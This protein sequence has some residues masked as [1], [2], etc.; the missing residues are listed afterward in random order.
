MLRNFLKIALRNLLRHKAFSVINIAGLA[1]GIS[2]C[3]LIF[4]VVKY[5]LSYEKFQPNYDRIF[6]VVSR[7]SFSDGVTYNP[8]VP[9]PA[10]EAMRL[11][12]PKITTGS[13]LASY[14]S[15]VTVLGANASNLSNDKKF[16]EETG[17]FFCDPQFFKV[18]HYDWLLGSPEVLSEPNNTVLTQ[19]TAKRYFGDWKNAIGQFLKFDNNITV[20]VAGILK[21]PPANT[22]FPIA[23]VTSFETVKQNG[24][25]YSY[26]TQWGSTT[27]NFQVFMLLP[28][29]FSMQNVNSQFANFN[30][31][32]NTNRNPGNTRSNFLQPLS[33]V[34]FDQRFENFG[35]HRASKP[36][37]WTL[38]LIGLFIIVMACINFINLSTAQA[39]GRSKEIGIR[40]V[41]GS[42]RWQLFGQ[43]IGE[44]AF[45]V[46]AALLLAVAISVLCLPSIK[47]IALIKEPIS[48]FS[49]QTFYFIIVLFAA[50]IVLAGL[51][52]ALALSGFSPALALKN[53]IT[54]ASVGGI[55]IRRSLVVTQFAISQI[56]IIGTIV[57]ITQMSFVRNADLGF[58]QDA[59]F[60]INSNAD[61][62]MHA[63]QESFKQQLLQIAGVQKVS[64]SNDVPSSSNGWYSN[65]AFDH[66]PGEKFQVSLKFADEDYFK[67]FGLQFLAGGAFG[68][69]DTV[70]DVVINETMV[71]KLG[72]KNPEEAI[73][74]EIQIGRNKWNRISGVLRD[75]KTS[76]LRE[77]IKPTLIGSDKNFYSVTA[78]KLH[79][80][81]IT[82]TK[83]NIERVWN[84]S[85]PEYAFTSSYLDE[86]IASFYEQDYQFALLYKI[87]AGIAIFISCL[88][89]YGLVSFMA[90]QKTK[91]IGIRKVLGASV[92]NIIYLFSKEFTLLIFIGSIIAIPIAYF[93]M[94][95]W[96]QNFV[97]RIKMNAGIFIIAIVLSL[98]IAWIAVGYKSIKAALVNPVKS[99]KSE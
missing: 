64:F 31:K 21:D 61:S 89:L 79:S 28:P 94:N 36:T 70:K 67:T 52:P 7:D 86:N 59:V 22:D 53:K 10:L 84:K 66:R 92:K 98:F 93:M 50:V 24:G 96:L 12:F 2:A 35:D 60:L 38:S 40:K 90:V 83:A 95:N 97:F 47:L 32:N 69:S 3:L 65:F 74:K 33:E 81:N 57:A 78:I 62:T 51:Y 11:D 75:F 80:S 16:I 73:G 44:T 26:N 99:L 18:F 56:L 41:L 17:F 34:H 8:G 85:F 72:L 5:E 58:N 68:K 49:W 39:V 19:K 46:L 48:L 25:I 20:K 71:K 76:S 55:S 30:S 87:F 4:T 42:Y 6:H 77:D 54:S 1:I 63:R 9:F 45:I 13:L 23:I 82:G 88:G 37:L 91:E 27:S 29:D 15:Q 14:G 43:I